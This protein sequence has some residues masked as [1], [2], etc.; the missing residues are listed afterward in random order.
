[1]G[2]ARQTRESTGLGV[3]RDLART[4]RAA[5]DGLAAAADR[6]AGPLPGRRGAS[7]GAGQEG[8]AK[9]RRSG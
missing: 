5:A 8:V 1:L 2:E 9:P 3:A 7:G 6:L 4:L